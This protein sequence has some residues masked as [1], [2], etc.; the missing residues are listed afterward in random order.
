MSEHSLAGLAVG[1][2]MALTST[3]SAQDAAPK[4]KSATP[5]AILYR[6]DGGMFDL[7]AGEVIDLTDRQI[8]LTAP[9]QERQ[10][11]GVNQECFSLV[12]QSL[13]LR[14]CYARGS[15]IDL[16]YGDRQ[17]LLKD[18]AQCYL[19]MIGIAHPKGA[20]GVATLRFVC[21]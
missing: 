3:A 19:E 1:L 21:R 17:G 4:Q 14:S 7:K 15:R 6:V 11:D 2:L 16:K 13:G 9:T 10:T 12:I 8:L 20:P 5:T 18:K